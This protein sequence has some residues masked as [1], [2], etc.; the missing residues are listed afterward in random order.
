[1]TGQVTAGL[2]A[3]LALSGCATAPQL[4]MLNP[5][6]GTTVDCQVPDLSAGAADFL[7]SRACV[8]ACEAHG[9]RPMPGVQASPAGSGIPAE[10]SQ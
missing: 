2:L 8:S 7:V 1:M 4:V 3:L 10:C 9:F 5:R 6:T